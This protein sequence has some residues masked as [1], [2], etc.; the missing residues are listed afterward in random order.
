MCIISMECYVGVLAI[1]FGNFSISSFD[2]LDNLRSK[3]EQPCI[4]FDKVM[5]YSISVF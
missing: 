3:E 5:E 4:P 2:D 1:I